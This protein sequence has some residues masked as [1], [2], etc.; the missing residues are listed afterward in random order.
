MKSII[1][2]FVLLA[3]SSLAFSQSAIV[4][5]TEAHWVGDTLFSSPYPPTFS[6]DDSVVMPTA[7]KRQNPPYPEAARQQQLD[8][9]VVVNLWIDKHGKPLR[10]SIAQTSGLLP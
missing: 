6:E 1:F 4:S 3:L 8:G 2:T 9:K 7:I 10:A 5:S